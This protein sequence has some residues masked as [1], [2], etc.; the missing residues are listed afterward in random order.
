MLA[1]LRFINEERPFHDSLIEFDK[2]PT[3]N[4]V[5]ENIIQE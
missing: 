1:V 3:H 5:T 2:N 4:K